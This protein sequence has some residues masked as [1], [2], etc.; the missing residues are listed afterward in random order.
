MRRICDPCTSLPAVRY[1][2]VQFGSG[3]VSIAR[4][5]STQTLCRTNPTYN[6]RMTELFLYSRNGFR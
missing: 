2:C 4:T 6:R 5:G 3:R 1:K